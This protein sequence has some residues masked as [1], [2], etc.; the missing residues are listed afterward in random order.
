MPTIL[1][2][3]EKG[4]GK[5]SALETYRI[6]NRNGKGV[7]TIAVTEKTGKLIAIKSVTLDQ[8][9]MIINKSGITIRIAVADIK[10]SGRLTQGVKIIDIQKRNDVISSVCVV[11]HED[12]EENVNDDVNLNDNE[13]EQ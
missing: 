13:N 12:E 5:R 8:D 11:E 4:V 2:L 1:V 7:K 3:S 10:Q 9:I 6:T